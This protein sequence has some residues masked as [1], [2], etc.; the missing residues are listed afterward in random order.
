M[1]VRERSACSISAITCLPDRLTCRSSSSS[2]STP[3][4][5][6]P[7]SRASAGG[8]ST[9][10][11]VE[12]RP[13]LGQIV[14]L[15]RDAR[16]SAAPAAVRAACARAGRRRAR[17]SIPTRSR[18][19]A[20][21]SAA[22]ATSRSRSCTCFSDFPQLRAI[23][24]VKRQLLDRVEAV[25]DRFQRDK[26][27]EQP[28]AQEASAHRRDREIQLVEQRVRRGRLRRPRRSRGA[29]A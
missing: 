5:I 19:P 18:G 6:M 9:S 25:A 13:Q 1:P 26:R 29:S 17:P 22:R 23:D 24:A 27:T 3:S 4:R 2:R 20:T 21:P 7:P 28:S 12:P 10:T 11:D 14:E 8:S 15:R 16:T